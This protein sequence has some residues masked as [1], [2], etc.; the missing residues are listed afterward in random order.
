[1]DDRDFMPPNHQPEPPVEPDGY[2]AYQADCYAIAY[3]ILGTQEDAESCFNA[4]RFHAREMTLPTDT[5]VRGAC[6]ERLTRRIA[7]ERL[8]HIKAARPAPL[9]E[10]AAFC[11]KAA[12]P[13]QA[14]PAREELA[15]RIDAFL[16]TLSDR[17]AD[18]F[19]L[20]YF[21]MVPHEELAEYLGLHEGLTILLLHRTNRKFKKFL[22]NA[23]KGSLTGDLLTRAVGDIGDDLVSRVHKEDHRATVQLAS[24][25]QQYRLRALTASVISLLLLSLLYLSLDLHVLSSQTEGARPVTVGG[26]YYYHDIHRG[27]YA[28]DPTT[29]ERD[30]ILGELFH[31][32]DG[33]YVNEE[34]LYYTDFKG[35]TLRVRDHETGKSRILYRTTR[36]D[37]THAELER[38]DGDSLVYCLYNRNEQCSTVLRL[39][40]RTG[41]VLETIADRLAYDADRLDR[42][43]VGERALTW[44]RSKTGVQSGDMTINSYITENG[45]PVFVGD[46]YCTPA[47]DQPLVLNNGLPV[48]YGPW[49]S[50]A[51][52]AL[53][54]A[55]G[56]AVCLPTDF[57]VA[58]GAGDYLYGFWEKSN[59]N[60]QDLY[61]YCISTGKTLCLMKEYD[62]HFNTRYLVTDGTYLYAGNRSL[63]K[64]DVYRLS[65]DESGNLCGMTPIA[66]IALD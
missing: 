12:E 40:A 19:V 36:D 26:I 30:L 37:C 52:F 54:M 63:T 5:A 1:M 38:V 13:A 24:K 33:I 10:L 66:V 41:E 2:S 15:A 53:L 4:T 60:N 23:Y 16:H 20:R 58:A 34:G 47:F 65:Y 27:I 50:I 8:T 46:S 11:P 14:P 62:I 48:K 31:S 61:A 43:A 42:I 22:R 45:A 55:D 32:I 18:A 25:K 17:A 59:G 3:R 9:E 21:H 35:R 51:Y 64:Y 56:T 6:L 49:E 7:L 39:D 28:Y 29:G 57:D 44:I